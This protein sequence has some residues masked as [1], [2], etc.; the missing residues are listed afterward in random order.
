MHTIYASGYILLHAMPF[1]IL[2]D[3]P[4]PT[5]TGSRGVT[6][7][8]GVFKAARW[9]YKLELINCVKKTPPNPRN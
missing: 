1:S 9:I 7:Y 4:L 6:T 3:N 8:V 2:C 5:V